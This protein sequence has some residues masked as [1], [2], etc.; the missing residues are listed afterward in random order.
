MEMNN[1]LYTPAALPPGKR[2]RN[3]LNK[4]L[5]GPESQ[6]GRFGERYFGLTGI[7]ARTYDT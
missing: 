7:P 6:S 3:P 2:P 1:N 5:V 4:R